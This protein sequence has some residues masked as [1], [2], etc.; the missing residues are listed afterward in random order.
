MS[1]IDSLRQLVLQDRRFRKEA[2]DRARGLF[3]EIRRNL[4]GVVD[5]LGAG[6]DA[7]PIEIDQQN[8]E[9]LVVLLGPRAVHVVLQRSVGV[10]KELV[11]S[12]GDTMLPLFHEIA[13]APDHAHPDEHSVAIEFVRGS[14][15]AFRLRA[16]SEALVFATLHVGARACV[17]ES[18]VLSDSFPIEEAATWLPDVLA[19]LIAQSVSG[20]ISIWPGRRQIGYAELLESRLISLPGPQAG[21]REKRIGFEPPRVGDE[22][23]SE[24][25]ARPAK[26]N[27]K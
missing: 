2:T 24:P 17:L 23:A 1:A 15:E 4:A 9:H 26:D 7:Y 12:E 8:P 22:A 14:S 18:K 5:G 25:G 11:Y 16:P 21:V 20:G 13:V 10:R 6:E 27:I 19:Q 3:A